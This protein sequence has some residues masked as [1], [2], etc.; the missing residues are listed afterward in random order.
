A[1]QLRIGVH[2]SE[3][4]QMSGAIR[5]IGVHEAARIS[6]MAGPGEILASSNTVDGSRY[7]T[8]GRREVTLKGIANPVEIESVDWHGRWSLRDRRTLSHWFGSEHYLKPAPCLSL[9]GE[10]KE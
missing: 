5:G 9:G 7:I 1:P 2:A 10:H 8:S 3:A 6:A 4:T